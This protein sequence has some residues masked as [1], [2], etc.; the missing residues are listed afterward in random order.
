M[1]LYGNIDGMIKSFTENDAVNMIPFSYDIVIDSNRNLNFHGNTKFLGAP[2]IYLRRIDKLYLLAIETGN[3]HFAPTEFYEL[4]VEDDIKSSVITS[5]FKHNII[6][7]TNLIIPNATAIEVDY[8]SNVPAN[9]NSSTYKDKFYYVK[10]TG[11]TYV[12]IDHGSRYKTNGFS[13]RYEFMDAYGLK[14]SSESA[15]PI[16][17]KVN[18]NMYYLDESTGKTYQCYKTTSGTYDY[19]LIYNPG[20]LNQYTKYTDPSNG[21]SFIFKNNALICANGECVCSMVGDNR[22]NGT[23]SDIIKLHIYRRQK[24]DGDL[25]LMDPSDVYSSALS[26]DYSINLEYVK[27]GTSPSYHIGIAGIAI[28]SFNRRDT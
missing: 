8:E 4:N 9:S 28:G 22:K 3:K 11:N 23:S 20:A 13:Y 6:G 5:T 18:E 10:A 19:K 14:Y 17:S 26:S 21:T 24:Y 15:F 25:E 16:A 1:A 27:G 2:S 12:C 7:S